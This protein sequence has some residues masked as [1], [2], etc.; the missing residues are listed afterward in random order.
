MFLGFS[1]VLAVALLA[2]LAVWPSSASAQTKKFQWSP[3]LAISEQYVS[4]VDLTPDNEEE[5]WITRIGPGVTLSMLFEQ[6]EVR[7]DYDLR[8]VNYANDS[9]RNSV[10]HFFA[11]EANNVRLSERVTFEADATI[12]RLE[13]PISISE[14][15]TSVRR[16]REPYWRYIAGGRVNYSFGEQDLA[17]V[18]FD[19]TQL[20]DDDPSVQDSRGY[21]P[22]AGV[23]YWLNIRNGLSADFSF[24]KGEFEV[25]SDYD[26]Y[27]G[28]GTYTHRFSPRTQVDLT[29]TY[30]KLEY[31][32]QTLE[33]R[34][35]ITGGTLVFDRDFDVHSIEL[36]VSHQFTPNIAGSLSGG[37]FIRRPETGDDTSE[38][39]GAASLS[40]TTERSSLVLDAQGGYRFQS[41]QAE[42]LNFSVFTRA[43][44]TFTYQLLERLTTSLR[45]LYWY[46]D[47]KDTVPSRT[48]Q[49][50]GG[51]AALN[52]QFL[53]WL[54]GSLAYQ[55]RERDSDISQNDYTDHRVS[56]RLVV[57]Y[58][59]EP[60]PF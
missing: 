20:D 31:D 57:F 23:S 38:P 25:S 11:L 47:Y 6:A 26:A 46:D 21:G 48:D 54:R 59:S 56:L 1:L 10:N 28:S 5:D 49:T 30:D 3:R 44:A 42:N 2:G 34:V 37:Y 9:D 8:Y 60:T 19:F 29:Y 40:L 53:D 41:L 50:F 14:Q 51:N 27:R 13:D 16:G 15:V 32:E 33:S 4:N 7:L 12:R 39:V 36:G 17:Y 55:Y 45:A 35:G 24:R 18:G 43:S 58:L 52:Y 22:T